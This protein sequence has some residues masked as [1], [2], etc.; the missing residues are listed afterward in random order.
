MVHWLYASRLDSSSSIDIGSQ[1]KKSKQR[2]TM[3]LFS[4]TLCKCRKSN[5]ETIGYDNCLETIFCHDPRAR[6]SREGGG[7][8]ESDLIPTTDWL[9]RAKQNRVHSSMST[10]TLEHKQGL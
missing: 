4:S 3:V 8:L 9:C 10:A 2:M 6:P 1:K 7:T 5:A